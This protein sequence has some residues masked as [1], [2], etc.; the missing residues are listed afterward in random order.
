LREG[1]ELAVLVYDANGHPLIKLEGLTV[2]TAPRA[3]DTKISS[4][5]TLTIEDRQASSQTN[6]ASGSTGVVLSKGRRDEMRG[7]GIE[8]CMEWD[9]KEHISSLLKTPRERLDIQT[10]LADIGFDSISLTEMAKLL[11][12]YYG[13]QVTPSIFF[14]YPTIEEIRARFLQEY[15]EEIE[16]FYRLEVDA[17]QIKP[18]LSEERMAVSAP[19]RFSKESRFIVPSPDKNNIPSDG[20]NNVFYRY[21]EL[22]LL[23]S[24]PKGRPIFW[25]HAGLGGVEIYHE[26]AKRLKRP[27]YGVQARGWL[28]DEPPLVGIY[29][30]AQHYASILMTVQPEGPFDIGGYSIGGV[31]S[32]EV[33]RILQMNKRKVNTI[34]MIDSLDDTQFKTFKVS[35]K[36]I[37]LQAVNVALDPLSLTNKDDNKP[38]LINR[39]ELDESLDDEQYLTNLI[40]LARK[41]ELHKSSKQLQKRIE[42]IVKVQSSY[43]LD[44]YSLSP[45]SNPN[46]VNGY[47]FRNLN[48]V[49]FGGLEPYLIADSIEM[50]VDKENYGKKWPIYLPD[51]KII[52]V[53]S[54]NHLMMLSDP[55]PAKT[56]ME[57]CETLYRTE[58]LVNAE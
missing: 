24:K 45:L 13:I 8:A 9:L 37:Y 46:E 30:M 10:N 39:S 43:E 11:S 55:A 18:S 22:V 1:K 6:A 15:S 48:S 47:Y 38:S 57:F 20:H 50:N 40:A 34:T 32:Y 21:P 58:D 3:L 41:R 12:H 25:M 33:T 16:A 44:A 51:I 14:G 2:G 35:K 4:S 29:A 23:N 7:L 53:N 54:E 28:D 5:P 17:P 42:R 27:F 31:L 26:I 19:R 49:F 56:I 36:S 52:E